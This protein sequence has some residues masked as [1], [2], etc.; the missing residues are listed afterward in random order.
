M[1]LRRA[2]L[3]AAAMVAAVSGSMLLA[4]HRDTHAAPPEAPPLLCGR[5]PAL[6]PGFGPGSKAGMVELRGGSFEP[7]SR[8]GYPDERPAGRVRVAPFWIDRTEVTN[9]QFEAFVKATGHVTQAEREGLSA[10]FRAPAPGQRVQGA[11]DWWRWTRGASWRHPEGPGSDL[12]GREQQPV[13]HV[14]QADALAYA[15]WLGRDLPT[16]DEWEFAARGGGQ[17]EQIEREPRTKDGKPTANYWQG[18]FPDLNT[19]EDGYAALAPVGCFPPNGY[20]LFDMIGNVWELTRDRYAGA[21]QP[22]FNGDPREAAG[23]AASSTSDAPQR[24]VIKG[25]SF[26]CA[27]NYCVRYRTAAR[28]AQDADVGTSHVGFRTVWRSGGGPG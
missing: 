23:R 26:L 18:V 4:V 25:G 27:T 5:G 21:R 15:R 19:R 14:T 28:E 13:I 17:P 3:A 20:G 1:R 22:H 6:P 9:A 10:V 2:V 12:R 7:G 16:E 8:S 24:L 11:Q